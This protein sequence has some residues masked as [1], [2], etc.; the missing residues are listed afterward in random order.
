MVLFGNLRCE[1]ELKP[2]LEFELQHELSF[3]YESF[4]IHAAGKSLYL[5][6]TI[7]LDQDLLRLAMHS[8]PIQV[9]RIE[10]YLDLYLRIVHLCIPFC[11]V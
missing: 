3:P 6:S 2:E 8:F 1:L 11:V 9:R 5:W 4:L 10:A 7:Y